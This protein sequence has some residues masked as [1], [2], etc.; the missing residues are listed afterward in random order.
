VVLGEDVPATFTYGAEDSRF[1][2]VVS[3]HE[4]HLLVGEP[5]AKVAEL[6]GEPL[7]GPYEWLGWFGDTPVQAD[8]HW[9]WEDRSYREDLDHAVAMAAGPAAVVVATKTSLRRVDVPWS[10]PVT[11][12]TALAVGQ[13]RVLAVV[14]A[15]DCRGQAWSLEGKDLGKVV[16]AGPGGAITE[17]NGTVWAGNPRWTA[18]ADPGRV[19]SED[20]TCIE[21]EAGDHLGASLGGGYAVGMFNKDAN[22]PRL[23]VVPLEEGPVY[24]MEVG[25]EL[26]EVAVGGDADTLVVGA[27][28]VPHNGLPSGVVVQADR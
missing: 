27:P 1:G 16:E 11:G 18:N 17:W 24:V 3:L 21:G 12:I 23:R 26:Q 28:Y 22:P 25:S 7:D 19:C 15:P 6:D 20:G 8:A 2:A 13:E 5:G 4:G 10:V 14:C 9:L